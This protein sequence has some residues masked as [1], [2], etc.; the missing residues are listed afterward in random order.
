MSKEENIYSGFINNDEYGVDN[1][2]N[3]P[4]AD[5]FEQYNGK[6]ISVQYYITDKKVTPEQAL[7]ASII[8]DFGGKVDA[9]YVLDAYSSWTILELIQNASVG[10]HNIYDELSSYDG[11]Y[12]T[13]IIQPTPTK[14]EEK[15]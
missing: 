2:G 5:I 13:L 4:I 11:K 9:E 8:K 10:G 14:Q 1:I 15:E 12:C 7:E 3:E 6:I